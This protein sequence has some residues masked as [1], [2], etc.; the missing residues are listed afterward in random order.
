MGGKPLPISLKHRQCL[1][2][3]FASCLEKPAFPFDIDSGGADHG[4]EKEFLRPLGLHPG[5][6]Q[7]LM[8]FEKKTKIPK[9]QPL[10]EHIV[11]TRSNSVEETAV[12]IQP[13][14][15]IR[16]QFWFRFGGE[17]T[18]C[19]FTGG[20]E[21]MLAQANKQRFREVVADVP[22]QTVTEWIKSLLNQ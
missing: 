3:H 5:V 1:G 13:I 16:H 7:N 14:L 22:A 19:N 6:F 17:K 18:V 21:L 12:S 9:H 8:Y 4:L 15:D 10:P 20:A 2:R 11:R